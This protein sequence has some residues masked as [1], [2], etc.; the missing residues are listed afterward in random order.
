MQGTVDA[1]LMETGSYSC[2]RGV[3]GPP[4]DTPPFLAQ[5]PQP[6]AP[7]GPLP[8]RPLLF[9]SLEGLCRVPALQ[10]A[11]ATAQTSGSWLCVGDP[12][13]PRFTVRPAVGERRPG[14]F[15]H[16]CSSL[17]APASWSP[18]RRRGL[19]RVIYGRPGCVG[20]G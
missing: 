18:A 6:L 4:G 3:G 2:P 20:G 15:K 19:G 13:L 11:L 8:T 9:C 10:G 5:R 14:N 12:A 1:A 16:T 17:E 7:R